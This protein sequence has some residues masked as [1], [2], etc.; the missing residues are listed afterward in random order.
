M[1]LD[2]AGDVRRTIGG[3][4][5]GEPRPDRRRGKVD[6]KRAIASELVAW[7]KLIGERKIVIDT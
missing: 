3:C 1:T 5:S 2:I 7:K 4:S 6:A